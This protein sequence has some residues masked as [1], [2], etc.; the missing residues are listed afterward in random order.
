MKK[1]IK[2][3]TTG[4]IRALNGASGPVHNAFLID[5]DKI[6]NI[7]FEGHR[8]IEILSDGC[9]VELDIHNYNEDINRKHL[10]EVD[11]RK[12]LEELSH[13]VQPT[14]SEK[15]YISNKNKR[16]KRKNKQ[17]DILES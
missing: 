2:I 16:Q 9:E 14:V 15:S 17:V 7:L 11:H 6:I 8:V 3:P 12:K 13:K 1:K 5:A 10:L 4:T